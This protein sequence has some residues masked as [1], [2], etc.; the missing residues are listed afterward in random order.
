MNPQHVINAL[1]EQRNAAQNDAAMARASI[2]SMDETAKAMG[3][4]VRSYRALL[5]DCYRSGQIPEAAWQEYLADAEF[6][7]F[8]EANT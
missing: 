7:A 4:T 5:L 2:V 6:A 1:I 3:E 8:V